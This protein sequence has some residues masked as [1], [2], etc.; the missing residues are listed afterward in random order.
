MAGL[1]R[2]KSAIR[3]AT[4]VLT[5]ASCADVTEIEHEARSGSIVTLADW[6]TSCQLLVAPDA[7]VLFDACFRGRELE[8]SLAAQELEPGDVTHILLTHGHGDHI[9]ALDRLENAEVMALLSE[10]EI[11]QEAEDGPITIDRFLVDGETLLF[12][13]STVRVLAVPGHTPGSAVYWVDGALILGDAALVDSSG[14]LVPVPEDR[15]EDP[16]RAAASLAQLHARVV[17]DGLQVDWLVPAH[18]G[19]LQG[20]SALEKY[21][22]SFN[23]QSQ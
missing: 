15:S 8:K 14:S 10:E 19:R 18:S 22:Q 3:A 7:V 1:T 12:G 16:E 6:F 2:A 23:S 11:L 20:G 9:G 5:L 17:E 21:A 13:S 4:A